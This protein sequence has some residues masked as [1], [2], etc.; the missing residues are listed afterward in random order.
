MKYTQHCDRG[1]WFTRLYTSRVSGAVD[2]YQLIWEPYDQQWRMREVWHVLCE[3]FRVM[4]AVTR[5]MGGGRGIYNN[6]ICASSSMWQEYD[7]LIY[8]KVGSWRKCGTYTW[9]SQKKTPIKVTA[10]AE[11]GRGRRSRC[12]RDYYSSSQFTS[13]LANSSVSRLFSLL[14]CCEFTCRTRQVP[15]MP[16]DPHLEGQTRILVI[17]P[18]FFNLRFV[19]LL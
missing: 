2:L 13:H 4:S 1:G 9:W 12:K 17:N 16:S 5:G 11:L 14:R 8:T 3:Q 15:D 6:I 18:S 7:F 19:L 10:A